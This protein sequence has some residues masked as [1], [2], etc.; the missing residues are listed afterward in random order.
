MNDRKLAIPSN[1]NPNHMAHPDLC[2]RCK[3]IPA[4]LFQPV[5]EDSW[6]L[7][8]K[9]SKSYS[10]LQAS[11]AGCQ[12]CR[13][14]LSYIDDYVD[15]SYTA[16]RENLIRDNPAIALR[17]THEMEPDQRQEVYVGVSDKKWEDIEEKDYITLLSNMLNLCYPGE[18]YSKTRYSFRNYILTS[19]R[20]RD[21]A[22]IPRSCT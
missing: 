18:S 13:I 22:T 12:L 4:R 2:N 21:A 16:S 20:R 14:F 5:D 9:H 8:I 11:A 10:Q 17:T 19:S 7:V 15:E 6:S 3:S 1:P